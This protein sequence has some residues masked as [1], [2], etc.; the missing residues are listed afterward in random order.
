MSGVFASAVVRAARQRAGAGLR[1][2]RKASSFQEHHEKVAAAWQKYTYLAL[3]A[4]SLVAVANLVIHFSHGHHEEEAKPLYS[5]QHVMKKAFPW[6][7]PKCP[8]F[9]GKCI[10]EQCKGGKK[11]H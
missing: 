3:P 6:D 9:D 10:E 8:L 11:G 5:Y 7:C 1:Q 2:Q 4:V